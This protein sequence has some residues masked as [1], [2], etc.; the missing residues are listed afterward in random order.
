MKKIF[1][2]FIFLISFK[3]FSQTND[4]LK[5]CVAIQANNFSTDSD[6]QDAVDKILSVIGTSQKP[7]LQ[8]C[9]N[10]NNAVAVAY[11][12]QRYILYDR[13]FMNSLTKGNN[14]YW[15]NMF[16]LAHEVGHH[17]NGHSL[18]IILY[19][20]D[21]INPKSL[22]TRRKQELEAD[23]FAGFVL[24]KLGATLKQTSKVLLNLPRISNENTSTHP[25]KEKRVLSVNVGWRKG[26]VKKETK[27]FY[28]SNDLEEY[29]K[30][31]SYTRY[32]KWYRE[33]TDDI[34]EG[35][36]WSAVTSGKIKGETDYFKKAPI[37]KILTKKERVRGRMSSVTHM[38]LG[39]SDLKKLPIT[40][41]S[42]YI[43]GYLI[44][45]DSNGKR[46]LKMSIKL[47][48]R[49]FKVSK[50]ND[51][52]VFDGFWEISYYRTSYRDSGKLPFDAIE[53]GAKLLIRLDN[54]NALED[55]TLY[56]ESG[57]GKRKYSSYIIKT[58][59]SWKTKEVIL[60]NAYFEYSLSG[61]SKALAD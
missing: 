15:S 9:S 56:K 16:I 19:S 52:Y 42:P 22:S 2:L 24:A 5:L 44:V 48:D 57:Y 51:E 43:L 29:E 31:E 47:E 28:V 50:S 38:T 55:D 17:I 59:N 41:F 10:I 4:A 32:G 30:S 58:I 11:K 49:N 18:D 35:R 6:A 3:S 39:G 33:Q 34:F 37:L 60:K 36:R 53:K 61:S 45:L 12:G 20:K 25:L 1:Y 8:A 54:Y 21:V 23:E 13:A 46:T 14:K 27:P 7:V 40:G 26:Y